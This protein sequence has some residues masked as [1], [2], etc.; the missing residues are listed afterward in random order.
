M[1]SKN[2]K[3]LVIQNGTLIDGRGDP[4]V[5]N[6]A[7]A[8]VKHGDYTPMKA[9]AA[10]RRD[11]AYAVG[12]EGELGEISPDKLADVPILDADPLADITVLQGG[13]HLTAV[14]KDGQRVDLDGR[15]DD[16]E[17]MLAEG[18]CQ[19]RDRYKR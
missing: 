3:T 17:A 19:R 15:E 18:V 12:L 8:M 1:A 14:I 6:E 9:I 5:P 2:G 4:A 11:N 13:K 7:V 10:N 16:S